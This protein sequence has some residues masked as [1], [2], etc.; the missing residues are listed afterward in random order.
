MARIAD[1][2]KAENPASFAAR[3]AGLA[4]ADGA[5]EALLAELLDAQCRAAPAAAGAVLAVE[6]STAARVDAQFPAPG[7]DRRPAPWLAHALE[8]IRARTGND[9]VEV[10]WVDRASIPDLE[11]VA[12]HLVLVPVAGEASRHTVAA[13]L[14]EGDDPPRLRRAIE[15]IELTIALLALP[16]MRRAQQARDALVARLRAAMEVQDAVNEQ[17]RFKAAA[18]AL[19]NEVA[20]RFRAERVSFGLLAGRYVKTAAISHTERFDRRMRL[21]Q[22]LESAMEECLDQDVE[23]IHPRPDDVT[24]VS[25]AAADLAAKHGPTCV[26]S[27]PM[28]RAGQPVGVLTIERNL[29]DPLCTEDV[30]TL[31]VLCDLVTP[32]LLELRR[33]DRW[34]GARAASALRRA[35]AGLVGAK[36]TWEKLVAMAIIGFVAF[37]VLA[38]GDDRVDASF[39]ITAVEERMIAA[40][41]DGRLD[42][43]HVEPGDSVRAGETVLAALETAELQ[44]R[45]AEARAERETYLKQADLALRDR[46]TVE[47]QI[48]EAERERIDAEIARLEHRVASATLVAPI[49]GTVVAGDLKRS[50]GAPVQTGDTLFEIAELSELRAELMVP[51]D[52]ITDLLDTETATGPRQG[53]LASVAHPGDYITFEIETVNPVA[54][55]ID[56][57]NVFRVRVRL[58]EDR[59]WLRPG[60]KGVA[61]VS[62]GEQPYG[63]LWTRPMINWIRMKLWI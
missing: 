15:R 10:H 8:A 43:V 7:P 57:Q 42:R 41:F 27:L 5:P 31:R 6:S 46:K 16:D 1:Y 34:I 63:V 50:L 14:V 49:T 37:L 11:L 47:V 61:K 25:R 33:H 20:A 44:M 24:F 51:E 58:L 54:E 32:R 26:V 13:Y 4:C 30:E 18:I 3:V 38:H 35:A 17:D 45:L 22:D 36:H 62:V 40:P 9:A 53:R 60:M 23:V 12:P 21:V 28:R 48:A 19:S 59:D 52:R 55:V 2:P 56:R 29:D 39:E